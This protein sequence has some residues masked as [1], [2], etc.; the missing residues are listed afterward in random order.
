MKLHVLLIS[1]C[2]GVLASGA[3]ASALAAPY[4]VGDR[5]FPATPTTDYPFVADAAYASVSRLRQGAPDQA[6][7]ETDVGFGIEKRITADLGIDVEDVWKRLGQDGQGNAY[8]FDNVEATLKY[9]LLLNDP[10]EFL[11]SIG[12]T[13]EFGGSRAAGV[14]AEAVSA[15]T[16]TIYFGKG[17]GDLPDALKYLRPLAITGLVGYRIADE[18]HRSTAVID[19]ETGTPSLD[20]DHTPNQIVAGFAIE[21][22]LRYLQGNVAYLGLPSFLGRL[23]PLV[24][25]KLAT[26][27][28][29][30]FGTPTTG[31]IAPG[32]IYSQNGIDFGVEALVP[33]TRQSG[34]NVGFIASLHI[35]FDTFLPAAASKPLFGGE[36]P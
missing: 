27:T 13:R 31:I 20:I 14:G 24:E 2:A 18:P 15:T 35:P 7:R 4:V 17:F 25:V 32:L 26:P 1:A 29:T 34:T 36:R 22:S 33:M 23:T 3:F 5:V 19:A 10:H 8:G 30:S 11:F 9:Q 21:Y 12:I 16:P 6:T 28:G